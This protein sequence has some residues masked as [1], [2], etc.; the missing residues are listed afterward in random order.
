MAR[1]VPS[2]YF[3]TTKQGNRSVLPTSDTGTKLAWS[4]LAT[5]RASF[6]IG[7]GIAR[8]SDQPGRGIAEAR[9]KYEEAF[10]AFS[11]LVVEDGL[12]ITGQYPASDAGVGK[13]VVNKLRE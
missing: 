6:E 4:W 12:R 13:A 2:I 7:F 5:V 10:F 11:S 9:A 1:S 8:A 3:E